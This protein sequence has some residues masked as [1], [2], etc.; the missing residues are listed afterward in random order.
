M[1]NKPR[2]HKALR[3][4]C[5]FL[6][7]L[8]LFD[9]TGRFISIFAVDGLVFWRTTDFYLEKKNTLDVV[10]LGSSSTYC[11]W[12]ATYAW[13]NYGIAAYPYATPQQPLASTCYVIEECRKKQPEAVYLINLNLALV[14]EIEPAMI[15]FLSD[16]MPPSLNRINMIEGLCE[17]G[18]IVGIDN[19]LEYYYPIF[20]MHERWRLAHLPEK[21]KSG[22]DCKGASV[23]SLYLTQV[24]DMTGSISFTDER[25]DIPEETKQNLDEIFEYL[26]ENNIKA[27]FFESPAPAGEETMARINTVCDYVRDAGFVCYNGFDEYEQ[28]GL[29]PQYDYCDNSHTNI[30]GCRKY[31]AWLSE[32]IIDQFQLPDHRGNEIYTSWDEAVEHYNWIVRTKQMQ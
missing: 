7:L 6:I 30:S 24:E 2:K 20:A 27:A 25:L 12:D 11:F 29:D 26:R 9:I 17:K 10:V 5:F 18:N 1:S 32:K 3:A 13:S 31:T 28:I 14:T 4:V 8:I 21:N 22:K 15:H 23:D 16:V 19:K